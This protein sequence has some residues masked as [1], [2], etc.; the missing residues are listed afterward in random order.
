MLDVAIQIAWGLH[1]A[2]EQGLVHRDVKPANVL[3]TADGVAKVTDFGLARARTAPLALREGA[4]AGQTMTV[5]GGG[6]GTPAYASPEQARGE[7]MSRRSD[8]WSFAL[9]VLETFLGERRWEL[10]LAAP[11]VLRSFRAEGLR[12]E[13][14]PPM[15]PDVADLLDRCFAEAPASRPHDMREAAAVLRRAWEAAAGGPYPRQEPKGGTGSADA[16]NNRAVSLVDLGRAAEAAALWRRALSAEP[17][18]LEATYNSALAAWAEGSLAD[19][20]VVRR[21]DEACASHASSPRAP[22]LL[23]RLHVT[24]GPGSEATV[25]PAS[26]PLRT[27]RGLPGPVSALALSPDGRTVIAASGAEVRVWDAGTGRLL[28]TLAPEGGP[29]RALA[30]LPGGRFLLVGAEAAALWVWDLTSGRAVRS[31]ERQVGFATSLALAPGAPIVV[32]G[33]SD[34]TVRLFDVASGRCL[35][36]IAAHEDAVS[37]VAAGPGRIASVSRDGTARLWAR[38]DGRLL[39]RITQPSRPLAVVLDEAQSRLVVAGE[40]GVV[41][42]WGIRSH[43]LARSFASHAQAVH[44]L[45]LSPDGSLLLSASLD[46]T[47]RVFDAD[48]QR[49]LARAHLDAAV[50]ALAVGPDGSVWAAH[51]SAVSRVQPLPL[52]LPAPAL[53]RP[54]TASDEEERAGLFETRIA[55]ARQSFNEGNLR[56][57]FHLARTARAVPGRERAPDAL[58]LWDQLAARLP[59]RGLASAWEDATVASAPEQLLGVALDPEGRRALTAGLDGSVR[60][61]DVAAR[62]L[63]TTLGAHAGAATAATFAGSGAALSGGRDRLL[64]LWA[65]DGG[66]ARE[67]EGHGETV[68]SVDA[69]PDGACAASGSVDGTVRLWD[70]R[71]PGPLQVLAGHRATVSS[72]RLSP[73]GLLVASGGWDGTARLWDAEA[74]IALAVLEGHGANVT[75]VALHPAG[76]QVATGAEDGTIRVFDPRTRRLLRTLAGHGA[77]VTSVAFTP[78]GRFLLSSSRDTTLRAWDLRRGEEIRSLAHPAP[79]LAAA[80]ARIA[81]LVVTGGADGSLRAFRLDWDLDPEGALD[82]SEAAHLSPEV[83]LARTLASAPRAAALRDDLRRRAPAPV[84][85]IPK[86]VGG[87]ARSIP[88][89]RIALGLF[90]LGVVGGS[91]FLSRTPAPRLRLSPYLA[92]TIPTEL[93]LIDVGGRAAAACG[94]YGSHLERVVSGNPE[95]T[96][97]ACVAA[98]PHAGVV[99]D[100]LD[101]A[102]LADPDPMAGRRLRRNA[103]S[104]LSTARGD[105]LAALCARLGDARSEARTVASMALAVNP[106]EGASACVR[107]ALLGTGAAARTAAAFSLRQRLARGLTPLAHGWATVEALL[108]SFDP[109]ARRDGL[110]LAT[111]YTQ[112]FAHPAAKAL[113]EDP[114]PDVRAAARAAV[115]TVESMR[116]TDLLHGDV[117]P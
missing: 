46:R 60:L 36:E 25:R 80:L 50:Q 64:R 87:A 18:H 39:A 99:A 111:L 31:F 98:A 66:P 9:S 102:P 67:L 29:V 42:D 19:P 115:A 1:H 4:A 70:L 51:G 110:A 34:R 32:A 41:R 86:A 57:A 38:E 43:E 108:R 69:T 73:D 85:A 56:T 22:Q 88:W 14:R 95:S 26:P 97:V 107:D 21:L 27:L 3:L 30:L 83:V 58:A 53:C 37:A 112:S 74:G 90:L 10:G 5:E 114:D 61:Y 78:D 94:E 44:A 47:V 12:A 8:L 105:A 82:A 15:P 6:G 101:G 54:S 35:R 24:L 20:E 33:G 109:A 17:H 11:D 55:G 117:E 49:L 113:L 81:G 93:D 13:G 89:R 103:A 68:T 116:R 48:G 45:A 65:L 106:D 71:V 77:S 92:R 75:A 79:V 96:D 16:L 62:R 2:H 52:A 91:L 59:R 104:A 40:D 76:R 100:V 23:A 84:R 63:V 28:R 72:V 7:P